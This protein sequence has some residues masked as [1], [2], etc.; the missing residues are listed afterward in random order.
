M[1]LGV[2]IIQAAP[3]EPATI[4]TIGPR[5]A[6]GE[7]LAAYLRQATFRIWGGDLA[8]DEDF[9]LREVFPEWPDPSVE[10]PYPCA[11]LIEATDTFYEAHSLTP[12]P[13]EETLGVFDCPPNSV[14]PQTV[15]WKVAEAVVDFQLDFWLSSLAG[16][17]AVEAELG[18][19]FN[20][21][22]ARSGVLLGGHPRYFNR[23]VRATLEGHRR[24][25]LPDSV[26]P[27]E[28]RLQAS[29]RAEVGV[30]HLRRATLLTPSA[31]VNATDPNDPPEEIDP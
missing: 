17:Q 26:Y 28:R 15:L 7:V 9:Q 19:L 1:S 18:Q 25:D 30:V 16:R 6:M 11:S 22:Q 5:Q 12:T 24:T 10:L 8:P 23:P 13:L 29:V 4:A 3:L 31:F 14:P 21:G 2:P 20:P 27:N